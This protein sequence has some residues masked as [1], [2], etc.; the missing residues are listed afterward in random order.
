MQNTQ[1]RHPQ[2]QVTL[3]E[4][5][6]NPIIELMKEIIRTHQVSIFLNP[7]TPTSNNPKENEIDLKGGSGTL[8]KYKNLKGI[9]TA[10]HVICN[11]ADP[12]GIVACFDKRKSIYTLLPNES[13][14]KNDEKIY[15]KK[16]IN[17]I[18][19][20][21]IDDIPACSNP[22]WEEKKLDISLLLLTD[23][24]FNQIVIHG[25][26]KAI[27]L[28]KSQDKFKLNKFEY[29]KE[30]NWIGAIYGF[31]RA[32]CIIKD[33]R[34]LKHDGLD[35]TGF[36][37]GLCKNLL[38]VPNKKYKRLKA[39]FFTHE[40]GDTL[41]ILPVDYAGA[42]GGG[43]W[44]IAIND[45]LEIVELFFSG[46]FV[47]EDKNKIDRKLYSRGPISLYEIFCKY[48]DECLENTIFLQSRK[49]LI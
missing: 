19:I 11:S 47:A 21:T 16:Q 35:L 49:N 44:Q 8:I 12:S 1:S 18:D 23:E 13:L 31:A 46:I 45:R 6:N 40:I 48:L 7:D 5:R 27:D 4:L 15:I 22:K 29:L 34:E 3:G 37:H 24:D 14:S 28:E 33:I 9:L 26:K 32:D 17:I 38:K 30:Q 36:K 25:N 39:D 2:T 10:T 43:F 42:S 20:L 41:D